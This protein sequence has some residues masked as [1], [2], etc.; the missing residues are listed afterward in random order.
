MIKYQKTVLGELYFLLS[1]DGRY[2]SVSKV[3]SHLPQSYRGIRFDNLDVNVTLNRDGS[4]QLG[5]LRV[6]TRERNN[7]Y[8]HTPLKANDRKIIRDILIDI[9]NQWWNSPEAD[10]ALKEALQEQF[11]LLGHMIKDQKEALETSE[12][13]M[14]EV[15][16]YLDLLSQKREAH[17]TSALNS[18][19]R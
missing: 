7:H 3:R 9:I 19:L 8:Y 1:G 15:V 4:C 10:E 6:S 17:S 13:E 5:P 12:A 14:K 18:L 16:E 2:L 11:V